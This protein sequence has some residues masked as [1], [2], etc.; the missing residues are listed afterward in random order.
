MI[1]K[2]EEI[3]FFELE[4][5]LLIKKTKIIFLENVKNLETHDNGNT[6]E[7]IL[8]SLQ[9]L[10]YFVKYKVLNSVQ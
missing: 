5:I 7:T 8:S 2:G 4:R 6:M 10:G 3:Y 1:E 9:K